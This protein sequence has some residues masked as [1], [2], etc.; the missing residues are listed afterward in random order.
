VAEPSVAV[1]TVAG[2]GDASP[3]GGCCAV[4]LEDQLRTEIESWRGLQVIGLDAEAETVTVAVEARADDQ[5][6]EVLN[7]MRGLDLEAQ[8]TAQA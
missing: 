2:M 5:L 1:I 4:L 6:S 3:G 8:V 7:W